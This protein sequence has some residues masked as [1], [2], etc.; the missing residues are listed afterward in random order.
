M[1]KHKRDI[2]AFS[3]NESE[4]EKLHFRRIRKKRPSKK[5]WLLVMMAIALAY[6]IITLKGRI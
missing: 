3:K 6:L 5:L 1:S 2:F 4:E